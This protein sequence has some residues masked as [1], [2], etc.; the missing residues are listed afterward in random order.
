M[1]F[2]M[3]LPLTARGNSE[4]LTFVDRLLSKCI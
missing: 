4:I 1:D 3:G 2:N